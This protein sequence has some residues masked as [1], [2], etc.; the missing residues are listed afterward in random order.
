LPKHIQYRPSVVEKTGA[1]RGSFFAI[2][3]GDVRKKTETRQDLSLQDKYYQAIRIAN[4]LGILR[5]SGD[6]EYGG[7]GLRDEAIELFRNHAASGGVAHPII[8]RSEESQPDLNDLVSAAANGAPK[9]QRFENSTPSDV[10]VDGATYTVYVKAGVHVVCD[11]QHAAA[12]ASM[13]EWSVE[14]TDG[15]AVTIRQAIRTNKKSSLKGDLSRRFPRM[16]EWASDKISLAEFVW[17]YCLM[18]EI[19]DGFSV[20]SLNKTPG[21]V[22]EANLC[23][24]RKTG[25]TVPRVVICPPP[26]GLDNVNVLPIDMSAAYTPTEDRAFSNFTIGGALLKAAG[27]K[28]RGS[29]GRS[30]SMQQ[31]YEQAITKLG[32][33]YEMT[34]RDF[35]AEHGAYVR[36]VNEN[37]QI[38]EAFQNLA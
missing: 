27:V 31:K 37:A 15:A 23:L 16:R 34:G 21:D 38:S 5:G 29:T 2:E 19:P 1:T 9:R 35:N 10:T 3:Y 28:W 17:C 18:K 22:R 30:F 14:R 4:D 32:E 7:S 26:E 6:L 25:N 33:L 11:K 24:V 12:T 13:G 8:A 36:L 20:G